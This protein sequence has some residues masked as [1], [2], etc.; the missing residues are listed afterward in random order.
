M[1]HRHAPEGL[2]AP[3]PAAVERGPLE[4]YLYRNPSAEQ[5]VL[6]I[7]D[8]YGCNPFYQSFA[9]WINEL[10]G[11]VHLVNPFAE[12][13]ELD[14]VTREAAFARRHKLRDQEFNDALMAYCEDHKVSAVIGFCLGGTFAFEFARRGYQ[15]TLVAYYPFPQG[16]PNQD[17]VPAPFDYLDDL[18]AEVTVLIGS[19][20]VPVTPEN[21][22]RLQAVA[23]G[24]EAIDLTVYRGSGHGFLADLESD[25][26]TLKAH[27]QDALKRC[28]D[29]IFGA[30]A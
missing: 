27:A 25:D 3:V 17:P 30:A 6:I 14:E 26:A 2:P 24:N 12:F 20:D 5:R 8:I 10:G 22:V 16:L 1:C 29:A 9:T 13:G 7:P 15:G 21:V 28:A 18:K 11:E 19:E 23:K 4:T